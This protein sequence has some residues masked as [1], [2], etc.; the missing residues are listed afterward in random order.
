MKKLL[1]VIFV[2]FLLLNISGVVGAT[3]LTWNGSSWVG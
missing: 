1:V 2:I 3:V